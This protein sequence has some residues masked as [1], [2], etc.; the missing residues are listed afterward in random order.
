MSALSKPPI[1]IANMS[2]RAALQLLAIGTS[3]AFLPVNLA[4]ADAQF[5]TYKGPISLGFSFSYPSEW[6]VK[7]KPI[8]T[9]LSEVIVTSDKETSTSA[10]LVVDAVKI[11]AID[12]FG[13]PDVVGNKVVDM[14]LRKESVTNAILND[15]TSVTKDGLTY[16]V[17]DYSVNSTRGVKRYQAKATITGNQLYVFT[18]QA[19]TDNFEGTTEQI[20]SVMLDSFTVARQYL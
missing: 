11:D 16:Y 18:A 2:R 14:E 4:Y 20:F 13:T 10:G 3:T 6:I 7:K 19:K 8:K 15:A 1:P 12:K 9:H 5:K 17:V